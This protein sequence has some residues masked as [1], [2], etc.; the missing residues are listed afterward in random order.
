MLMLAPRALLHIRNT[1]NTVRI[2]NDTRLRANEPTY[3]LWTGFRDK[4]HILWVQVMNWGLFQLKLFVNWVMVSS[5]SHL[6]APNANYSNVLWVWRRSS[7]YLSG[8]ER[9]IRE[10]TFTGSFTDAD[11]LAI[12]NWWE[13]TSA[14][15]TKYLHYRPPVGEVWTTTQ[16]QSSNDRDWTLNG[17]VTRDYI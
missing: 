12:Y 9:D 1:L 15:V 11:A 2:R 7:T 16:D 3:N 4:V 14:W 8:N 17:G 13:P 10:Y 5:T 6:D